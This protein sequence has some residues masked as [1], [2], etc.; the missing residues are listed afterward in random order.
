MARLFGVLEPE[1][2]HVR[3]LLA[4]ARR[5]SLARDAF[6][7]K[8]GAL[9]EGRVFLY[10]GLASQNAP[11]PFVWLC[12]LFIIAKNGT[13]PPSAARYWILCAAAAC[14]TWRSLVALCWKKCRIRPGHDV[15]RQT[16]E[17]GCQRIWESDTP[18]RMLHRP[19]RLNIREPLAEG[20]RLIELA[21][22]DVG[23]VAE[24]LELNFGR[25]LLLLRQ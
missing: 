1:C 7:P 2:K 14:A 16:S 19:A 4:P 9:R 20:R 25:Q 8:T 15:L 6:P 3:A 21:Q 18:N 23:H 5:T 24:E 10:D 12:R 22:W 17:S 11:M 13:L